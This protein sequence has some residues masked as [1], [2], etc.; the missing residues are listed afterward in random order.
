M[1]I[2]FF[3]FSSRRRHT[4]CSRDWSSDVCSSDLDIPRRSQ[5]LMLSETHI[6]SPN[7]LN[8]VRLGFDR[9][10]LRVNQQNQGNNLNKAVG[11]PTVSTNPRDIG[12]SEIVVS[13]F[14]T[15]G[16]EINTPQRDTANTYELI[17]SASWA[18]G[19]HL[20]KFGIDVRRLQQ[21]GFADVESRGLLEFVGFTGNALAEM[22]Q[23]APSVTAIARLDNPQHL[24][25]QSYNFYAQDTWRARPNL[26]LTLG[27]RYEYN[28][29]AVDPQD[30]AS[31]YDRSEEHTSELQSRL[32]LVCRLLLEKKKK[33]QYEASIAHTCAN[34]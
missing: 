3:F 34:E 30:R 14:S 11:L 1:I 32:H 18:R 16:D 28:T 29:P 4:R 33:K 7:F 21:N 10:S 2:S 22:L 26:T 25:T 9:V 17:D 13:G 23:D 19:S 15:L 31:I 5:N 6:F 24:R 20:F 27:L 8:E 12:L